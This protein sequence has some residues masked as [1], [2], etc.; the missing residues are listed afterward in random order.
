MYK[1]LLIIKILDLSFKSF[2]L[3]MWFRFNLTIWKKCNKMFAYEQTWYW[4]QIKD[5]QIISPVGKCFIKILLF[6]QGD[7]FYRSMI[8]SLSRVRH[9]DCN[10]RFDTNEWHPGDWV[11]VKYA[12]TIPDILFCIKYK[13]K[14]LSNYL[15]LTNEISISYIFKYQCA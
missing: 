10:L 5:V 12:S 1:H 7:I 4:L 2:F 15:F 8:F 6:C 9:L 13:I 14:S 3:Q 11:D